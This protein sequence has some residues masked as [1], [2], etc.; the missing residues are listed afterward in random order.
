MHV[1]QRGRELQLRRD[2]RDRRD[3]AGDADYGAAP[4]AQ[5]TIDVVL[6]TQ[7]ISFTAPANGTVNGSDVLCDRLPSGLTVALTVDPSTTN[8]ACSLGGP[9]GDTVNYLHDGSC[10]LDANQA[11]DADYAA[12]PQVQQTIDV[13]QATQAISFTSTSPSPVTVGAASYTPTAT[14]T[15]GL[16]VAITLD[17]SSTGCTLSSGVV[18]F[19]SA[20]TCV[21]DANQAGNTDYGA[22]PQVQQAIDVGLNSQTISFTAPAHRTAN[23]SDV[24]A[25][26]ASSGLSVKLSV[27]SSTTNDAC[28]LVSDIVHYAHGGS[29]VIDANQAG[30]SEYGAAPQVQ[31]T[32]DVSLASQTI[33]F[34]APASGTVNGSD[35]LSPTASSGLPVKLSVDSSTTNDAC[36]LSVDTVDY[37][38]SGSCVIDA[39]QAGNT[40]YAAAQEVTQTIS[41]TQPPSPGG[42]LLPALPGGTQTITVAVPTL[43]S[44]G[45]SATLSATGGA[46]GSPVVFSVD[47]S[48]TGIAT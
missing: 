43:G 29:C 28:S 15:S 19:S 36:S 16:S 11:G 45:G 21:I 48:S 40:V 18:S 12:S 1:V 13:G 44:L 31:Q 14:S 38:Q 41:V 2:M 3:Q 42:G 22:A 10:V 17:S 26:T 34:T 27:D 35:D 30:N 32:I 7:T 5:Q 9:D 4:Q 46:S 47:A 39:N 25:P 8:G 24:L 23:G 20:G 33:S 37:L 6:A